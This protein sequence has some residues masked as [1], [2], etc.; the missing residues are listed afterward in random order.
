VFIPTTAQN[1]HT[2]VYTNTASLLL[3]SAFS[4]IFGEVFDKE[5]HNIGQYYVFLCWIPTW[6]WQKWAKK[7]GNFLYIIFLDM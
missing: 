3:I 6:R 2:K 5:K 4:A 1:L 7:W